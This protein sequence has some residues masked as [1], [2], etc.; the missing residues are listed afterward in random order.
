L[1]IARVRLEERLATVERVDEPIKEAI[2]RQALE[3]WIDPEIERRRE[4]GK[5]PDDFALSAA[6]VIFEPDAEAPDICPSEYG[7]LQTESL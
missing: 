6:Q 7:L 5:L 1:F 4:A 2:V 3:F